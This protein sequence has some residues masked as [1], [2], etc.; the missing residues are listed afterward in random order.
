MAEEIN[1]DPERLGSE[2]THPPTNTISD[3]HISLKGKVPKSHK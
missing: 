2:S 3:T 1:A